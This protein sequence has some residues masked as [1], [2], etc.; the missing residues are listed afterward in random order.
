M[1]LIQNEHLELIKAHLDYLNKEVNMLE[2]YGVI[3]KSRAARINLALSD[4]G[5]LIQGKNPYDLTLPGNVGPSQS[6]TRKEESG[7][8][9]EPGRESV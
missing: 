8:H 5:Q 2:N 9:D 6:D 7:L 4:I 3:K 1:L